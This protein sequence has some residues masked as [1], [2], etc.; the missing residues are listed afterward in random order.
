[1]LE[2]YGY[3]CA[4]TGFDAE[5]ALEAAHIIPY[6]KTE[7]NDPSNGILLRAD[8]HTLFDLNLL[9][10]HP[11]KMQ[12]LLCPNLL[13]TEYGAIYE[14]QIY[15]PNKIGLRPSE[16]LLRQRLKQCSWLNAD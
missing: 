15:V 9:A 3:K 5:A 12:V 14:K 10:I 4:I 8:L 1:L 16:E 13:D 6:I 11:D 7:N 2:A